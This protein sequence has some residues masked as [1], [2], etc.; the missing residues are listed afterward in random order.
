MDDCT[1]IVG[2]IFRDA[3]FNCSTIA[4][5]IGDE[6]LRHSD[7]V[8][9]G[10]VI[11]LWPINAQPMVGEDYGSPESIRVEGRKDGKQRQAQVMVGWISVDPLGMKRLK[12]LEW[13]TESKHSTDSSRQGLKIYEHD[14]E[15]FEILRC[16]WPYGT[17]SGD[18]EDD[19]DSHLLSSSSFSSETVNTSSQRPV[20]S[21]VSHYDDLDRRSHTSPPLPSRSLPPLT[22]PDP[23]P[24]RA[25]FLPPPVTQPPPAPRRHTSTGARRSSRSHRRSSSNTSRSERAFQVVIV[26]AIMILAIASASYRLHTIRPISALRGAPSA[27]VHS[28]VDQ[29]WQ[30]QNHPSYSSQSSSSSQH[31]HPQYPN[32]AVPPL[33][34]PA[35]NEQPPPVVYPSRGRP[36][37][38]AHGIVRVRE[39]WGPQRVGAVRPRCFESRGEVW[40]PSDR[41]PDL[42][43]GWV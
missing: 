26:T 34:H 7:I 6:V 35:Q 12:L 4:G 10:L 18:D 20:R 16:Y 1:R 8:R 32:S 29:P 28:N 13:R 36:Y 14:P 31:N 21:L 43:L 15:E 3:G 38:P 27:H 33:P 23:P 19:S 30:S 17:R 11:G 2:S 42:H 9:T 39:V 40:C 24:R 25:T 22:I 37:V 41:S 5:Y